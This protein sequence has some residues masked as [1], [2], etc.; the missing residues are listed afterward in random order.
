MRSGGR[1]PLLAAAFGMIVCLLPAAAQQSAPNRVLAGYDAANESRVTGTV[2]QITEG[3]SA[4]G[5]LGTHLILD[6][7]DGKLDVHLGP[8]AFL[9]ANK[10]EFAPG[11][12]VEVVGAPASLASGKVFLARQ[13]AKGNQVLV[14]RNAQGMPQWLGGARR[15]PATA[16]PGRAQ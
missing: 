15:A 7:A 3:D 11:D 4:G 16:A 8:A 13:V 1:K 9:R 5:P 6:T 2:A 14:V 12:S 10:F